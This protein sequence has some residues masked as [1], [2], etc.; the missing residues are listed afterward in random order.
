MCLEMSVYWWAHSC[1]L[2]SSSRLTSVSSHIRLPCDRRLVLRPASRQFLIFLPNHGNR[3]LSHF[4]QAAYSGSSCGAFDTHKAGN[5]CG[6]YYTSAQKSS[7]WTNGC[8]VIYCNDLISDFYFLYPHIYAQ[9]VCLQ[10]SYHF[11]KLVTHNGS[12][13]LQFNTLNR[14]SVVMNH[15][16]CNNTLTEEI[17]RVW[18]VQSLTHKSYEMLTEK[19][20]VVKPNS[21]DGHNELKTSVISVIINN[22]L[23]ISS[24]VKL[25]VRRLRRNTSNSH[26]NLTKVLRKTEQNFGDSQTLH[27]LTICFCLLQLCSAWTIRPLVLT[28]LRV[29]PWAT[30]PNTAGEIDWAGLLPFSPL[31]LTKTEPQREY[32]DHWTWREISNMEPSLFTGT[33]GFVQLQK[34]EWKTALSD[35]V[36][37]HWEQYQYTH[38]YFQDII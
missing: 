23:V 35:K 2:L 11:R 30:A 10:P 6:N 9:N 1:A 29:W 33:W 4:H 22:T 17:N 5:M 15:S 34:R 20:S 21:W 13:Y 14:C 8:V 3:A 37:Q 7:G 38:F 24:G 25:I 18:V 36:H 28:M 27:F 31:L 19:Q 16:I 12:N 32:G 26:L